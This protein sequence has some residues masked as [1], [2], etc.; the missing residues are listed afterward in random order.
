MPARR[1]DYYRRKAEE[2]RPHAAAAKH[3]GVEESWQKVAAQWERLAR[4]IHSSKTNKSANLVNTRQ[5]EEVI[6]HQSSEPEWLLR[7][8]LDGGRI[9]MWRV[10]TS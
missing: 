9:K 3:A 7:M 2:R 10:L 8:V 5:P 1:A 6:E 4:H